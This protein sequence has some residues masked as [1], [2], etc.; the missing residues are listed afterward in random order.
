M[1]EKI[2]VAMSG[3]VDSGAAALLLARAGAAVTGVTLRLYDRA[4]GARRGC[5]SPASASEAAAFARAL[6][7]PH[8]VWDFRD[9]F[10]REVVDDFIFEYGRG[11]TPNPCVRCN[12]IIK[13]DVMLSRARALG[14]DALATGHYV[15]RE[16]DADGG[17]V[18]RR[19][20]DRAKDQSYFLWGTPAAAL[21]FLR[22]PV[23]D[24]TKTRVR[25]ILG[26]VAATAR[27]KPESQDV[28]FVDGDDPGAFVAAATGTRGVPGDILDEEGR[29]VGRHGGLGAFTVGQRRGLGVA[30]GER[31]YVKSVDVAANAVT[32]A[33]AAALAATRALVRG[34]NWLVA[35]AGNEVRADV[36]V[37]Y[38][39]SGTTATLSRI[40][41]DEWEAT[42]AMPRRALAPGQ[43]AAFFD[44]DVLLGG[45]VIH[46][47]AA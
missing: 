34:V 33:P 25:E 21:P 11:R 8:Y 46:E 39:D 32:L 37:R 35:P 17:W 26:E 5:C 15:R 4:A 28:C 19:G 47:V 43:S 1:T 36:M 44:G 2:L 40:G 18:L 9:V 7:I 27:T 14:F 45:G 42:F 24:F 30:A 29:V 16:R 10:R 31:L 3:G 6:G 20:A 22:F 38:R 12:H 41:A 13:F 23:G